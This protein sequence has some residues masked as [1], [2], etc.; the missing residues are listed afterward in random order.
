MQDYTSMKR[1]V[2]VCFLSFGFTWVG[3]NAQVKDSLQNILL[4]TALTDSIRIDVYN[5]LAFEL[6]SSQPELGLLYAD[7]ALQLSERLGQNRKIANSLNSFGVN[8]WYLGKD[9]LAMRCYS[10]VLQIYKELNDEPGTARMYNNLA[11]L[12]YNRAEY[13]EALH[14]H[15]MA[16]KIFDRHEMTRNLVNSLSNTGV[17]HLA[18]NDYPSALSYFLRA[19]SLT[20]SSSYYELGNL[21]TNIGLVY[22]NMN[23]LEVSTEHHL[24]AINY[25]EKVGNNQ[26]RAQALGNLAAVLQLNGNFREAEARLFEAL[27]INKQIGN[28]RRI[29][30]DYANLGALYLEWNRLDSARQYLMAAKEIYEEVK[31]P[32]NLS[33]VFALMAKTIKKGTSGRRELLESL[34]LEK[35]SLQNAK[36]ANAILR[37]MEAWHGMYESLDKLGEKSPALDAYINFVELKDSI[38]NIDN[39]KSLIR[40]QAAF[41]MEMRE[42]ELSMIHEL[43]RQSIQAENDK[44]S[45][46]ANLYLIIIVFA[47]IFGTL[48]IYALW[49]KNEANKE[50]LTAE[51]EANKKALELKALRAQ[52]NP[53]FIFNA[54]SSISNYLLKNDPE[55]ADYYLNRFARLIRLILLSSDQSLVK[56]SDEIELLNLYIEIESLRMDKTIHFRIINPKRISLTHLKVPPMI[57]QPIIENSIWHGISNVEREGVIELEIHPNTSGTSLKIRDNGGG[58]NNAITEKEKMPNHKSMGMQLIQSRLNLFASRKK[59]DLKSPIQWREVAGGVEVDILVP[60]II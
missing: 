8:Y 49:K 54:M 56:L 31:D 4:E 1:L 16:N 60:E 42:K 20:D 15:E 46:L 11:L 40:L 55:K 35:L 28:Q 30:S 57:L 24:S 17:V 5:E 33:F 37:Q 43:E 58:F 59:G 6:A 21:N 45:Y 12:S 51:F 36:E 47:L 38:Y 25:A 18:I 53:H 48:L 32:L 3:L 29:A 23:E 7:S 44:N 10:K 14:N 22:K 9:S 41:D 34:R 39:E 19:L 13:A 26:G 52:M 2:L 27:N 50:K